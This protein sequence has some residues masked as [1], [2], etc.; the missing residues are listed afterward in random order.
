MKNSVNSGYV[1][2]TQKDYS[3]FFKLQLVSE[4]EQGFLTK[5]QAKV[6]YGIQ[7][8]STILNWLKK[9]GNFDWEHES[10]TVMSKTPEQK[11]LELEAKIKLLEKQKN[12]AEHLAERADKKVIIFDMLVDLAEKEY[13]IDIRK[14]YTP[15]LSISTKQNAKKH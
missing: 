11:I 7:A 1:K 2:R 9:Y 3:I 14:N 12:R 6:K 13:S 4:I 5:S 10:I 8:G 15:E